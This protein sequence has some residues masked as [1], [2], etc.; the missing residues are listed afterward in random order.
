M[1]PPCSSASVVSVGILGS[2]R[3]LINRPLHRMGLDLS[4]WSPDAG[5]E[6]RRDHLI[7]K[8]GV[9]L[10]I[11]V[12]ANEGQYVR[13][14]R[15]RGYSGSVVSIEPLGS[16]FDILLKT[17][18][19]DPRWKVI[20]AAAGA[21][22]DRLDLHVSGNSA[23]SSLMPMLERHV[24]A[25]PSSRTVD[26]ES[27]EVRPLDRLIETDLDESTASF[28]KIDTQGYEAEVLKG[29]TETLRDNEVAGLEVEL[30]LVPLY[31]GQLLWGELSEEIRSLGFIAVSFRDG[32]RDPESGELLQVDGLFVRT[33]SGSAEGSATR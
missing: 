25:A 1:P 32:F 12:G 18:S 9:D 23:S 10:L 16:A 8:S 26:L 29:S 33:D 2:T 22:G 13:S 21:S 30:S 4:R 6:A 27:V 7:Q 11:D 15:D 20:K 28:I 19:R 17:S 5:F 3:R 24:K 14:L 31:E